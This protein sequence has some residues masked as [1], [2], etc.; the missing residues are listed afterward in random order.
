MLTNVEIP[1][2]WEESSVDQGRLP[3]STKEEVVFGVVILGRNTGEADP[4]FSGSE[5]VFWA[6]PGADSCIVEMKIF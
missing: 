6:S 3:V 4:T 1:T 2:Y 5:K